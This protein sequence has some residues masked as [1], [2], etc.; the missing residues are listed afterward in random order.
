MKMPR[1]TKY[2]YPERIKNIQNV[3]KKLAAMRK[4]RQQYHKDRALQRIRNLGRV[5]ICPICQEP[6]YK[7]QRAAKQVVFCEADARHQCHY[8]CWHEWA[9]QTYAET[10]CP[11]CRH[12]YTD[13]NLKM[14]TMKYAHTGGTGYYEIGWARVDPEWL[15]MDDHGG[16]GFGMADPFRYQYNTFMVEVNMLSLI[17]I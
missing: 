14:E 8:E 13:L 11:M 4:W 17:H 15:M 12:P 5:P 16:W 2:A 1:K 6:V 9:Q 10:T 7:K 3:K